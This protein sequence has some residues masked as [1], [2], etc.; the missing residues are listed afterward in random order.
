MSLMRTRQKK[1]R[2]R[3]RPSSE[4]SISMSAQMSRTLCSAHLSPR[5]ST[6]RWAF[7]VLSWAALAG[8]VARRSNLPG[9]LSGVHRALSTTHRVDSGRLRRS[10]SSR[11]SRSLPCL[12]MSGR[13]SASRNAA[14][15]PLLVWCEH[16]ILVKH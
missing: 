5:G 15:V 16:H 2:W 9:Y 12:E 1:P 11:C 14:A 13:A 10:R 3:T 8:F 4:N 7:V 6:C